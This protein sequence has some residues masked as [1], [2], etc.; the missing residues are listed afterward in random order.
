MLLPTTATW[1][2][3]IDAAKPRRWGSADA[4]RLLRWPAQADTICTSPSN[5]RRRSPRAASRSSSAAS[6][7]C[8]EDGRQPSWSVTPRGPRAVARSRRST[9]PATRPGADVVAACLALT[10]P[11]WCPLRVEAT[12]GQE[13][14]GLCSRRHYAARRAARFL[15]AARTRGRASHD[16]ILTARRRRQVTTGHLIL[17][18]TTS[19]VTGT[20][21]R[22]AVP[23][24]PL[25]P[26]VA[27][28]RGPP[29]RPDRPV[30]RLENVRV[31]AR[32]NAVRRRGPRRHDMHDG[33]AWA[34]YLKQLGNRGGELPDNRGCCRS[35]PCTSVLP[36]RFVVRLLLARARDRFAVVRRRIHGDALYYDRLILATPAI[37]AGD[38][39]L[40]LAPDARRRLVCCDGSVPPPRATCGRAVVKSIDA[41]GSRMLTFDR[42][43]PPPARA[44]ASRDLPTVASPCSPSQIQG[45]RRRR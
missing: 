14:L 28:A 44:G 31:A 6:R 9:C 21:A 38:R 4:A 25:P 40:A 42:S 1:R 34:R 3:S 17:S 7:A 37:E 29:A 16:E 19:R 5:L 24:A 2:V 27:R 41:A 45:L 32:G 33:S 10:S 35:E 13:A 20:T 11:T 43:A 23:R 26:R 22:A 15:G 8:G 18:C 36:L 12:I 39:V 30:A